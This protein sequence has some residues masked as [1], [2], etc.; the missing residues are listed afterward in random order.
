VIV[1]DT[2][3]VVAAAN[4]KDDYHERCVELLAGR[5]GRGKIPRGKHRHLDRRHFTVVRPAHAAAF[6]LLP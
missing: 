6:T 1:I 3:P 5:R 2:S 4:R